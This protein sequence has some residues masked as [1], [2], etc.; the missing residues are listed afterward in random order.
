MEKLKNHKKIE[1]YCENS[2][3]R[4]TRLSRYYNFDNFFFLNFRNFETHTC[5]IRIIIQDIRTLYF[6]FLKFF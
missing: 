1:L 4:D 2:I 6:S 5:W 3:F